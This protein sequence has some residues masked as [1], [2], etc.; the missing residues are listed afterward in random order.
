M[1]VSK[2]E[3]VTDFITIV[4]LTD[5]DNKVNYQDQALHNQAFS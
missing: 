2:K 4:N 3:I 5:Q 1:F